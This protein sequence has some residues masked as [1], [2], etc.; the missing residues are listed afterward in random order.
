MVD[1]GDRPVELPE[2]MGVNTVSR[3]DLNEAMSSLKSSMT[4]EVKSMFKEFLDT[5][6][7]S[8]DAVQVVNPTTSASDVN[9]GKEGASADKDNHS[10]GINGSG[11]FASVPPPLVYGGPVHPPHIVNLGPP[12]KLVKNDFANWV[13]RIESH[14]DHSSIQLMR[15]IEEGYYPRDPRN[16]TPRE[17]ADK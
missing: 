10:Q 2:A 16:L 3:E 17:E 8:I 5:L 12:P 14:L 4:T 7:L 11:T 15:V 13:F 9:S 6:K 1:D